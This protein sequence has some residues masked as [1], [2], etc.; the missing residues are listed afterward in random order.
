MCL[1]GRSGPDTWPAMCPSQACSH[2]RLLTHTPTRLLSPPVGGV[3]FVPTGSILGNGKENIFA[4]LEGVES[5]SSETAASFSGVTWL[6]GVIGSGL[7][8]RAIK[9][10]LTEAEPRCLV[11]EYDCGGVRPG[12]GRQGPGHRQCVRL[13]SGP[14]KDLV[15]WSAIC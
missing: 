3:R 6:L 13:A 15:L 11:Y 10:T 4:Q 2:S 12:Q 5:S 7:V 9:T 8:I 1:A 14:C